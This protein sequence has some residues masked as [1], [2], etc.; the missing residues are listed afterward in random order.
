VFLTSY[1]RYAARNS[2]SDVD[3]DLGLFFQAFDAPHVDTCTPMR[4][5]A[6]RYHAVPQRTATH[7]SGVNEP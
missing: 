7:P 4:C 2:D 6:L 5:I 1:V 3:V